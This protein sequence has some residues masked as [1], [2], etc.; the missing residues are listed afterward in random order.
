MIKLLGFFMIGNIVTN[1][2]AFEFCT[3]ATC[4]TFRLEPGACFKTFPSILFP[5]AQSSATFKMV[6]APSAWVAK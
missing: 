3:E 5:L 1:Y 2:I 4:Y 6:A